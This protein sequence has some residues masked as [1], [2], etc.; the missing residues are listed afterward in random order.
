ML[1]VL[2]L[3]SSRWGVD[4]SMR[5]IT[6]T[7]GIKAIWKQ[8]KSDPYKKKVRFPK[9]N[10]R[11]EVRCGV[12]GRED[13]VWSDTGHLSPELYGSPH[14]LL[15]DTG[16]TSLKPKSPHPLVMWWISLKSLALWEKAS[17]FTYLAF[18]CIQSTCCWYTLAIT[19]NDVKYCFLYIY[20]YCFSC[21]IWLRLQSSP[22]L[23]RMSSAG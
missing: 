13:G 17:G 15:V 6:P 21:F 12:K 11:L 14:Q 10:I 20:I 4:R 18:L 23:H 8:P 2:Y 9:K 7:H 19:E 5:Q 3:L 22:T 16:V 1:L